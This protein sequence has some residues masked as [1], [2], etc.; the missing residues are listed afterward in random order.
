VIGIDNTTANSY[1]EF[2]GNSGLESYQGLVFTDDVAGR[3]YVLYNH[4]TEDELEFKAGGSVTMTI[5]ANKLGLNDTSPTTTVDVSSTSN[6]VAGHFKFATV[7]LADDATMA[8][9]TEFGTKGYL[10]IYSSE[11]IG[12]SFGIRGAGNAVDKLTDHAVAVCDTADTDAKLCVISDGDGTY[13]LKNRRGGTYTFA[14]QFV[15]F[16]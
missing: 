8:L 12:C 5:E 14:I 3:G 10:T 6:S 1:I 16:E 11:G 4:G 15:G 2:R 9:E 13:T 7:S